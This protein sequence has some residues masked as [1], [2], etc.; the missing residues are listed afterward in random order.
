ML[1]FIIATGVPVVQI[2]FNN[3]E[4]FLPSSLLDS[5]RVPNASSVIYSAQIGERS[6]LVKQQ[7]DALEENPISLKFTFSEVQYYCSCI[8]AYVHTY[9]MA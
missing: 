9:S 4:D 8:R 6:R 5:E 3:L 2:L 7:S 1:A